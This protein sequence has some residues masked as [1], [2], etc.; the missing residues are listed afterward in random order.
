MVYI[1]DHLED[2]NG[3]PEI[4]YHI[5]YESQLMGST[6]WEI[7]LVVYFHLMN[8]KRQQDH[9]VIKEEYLCKYTVKRNIDSWDNKTKGY[10]G[11]YAESIDKNW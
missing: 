7:M 4:S 8:L 9:S 11:G 1:R 5:K 10:R 6:G 2:H 3:K